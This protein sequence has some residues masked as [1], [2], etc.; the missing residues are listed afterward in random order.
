MAY[1][2]IE[3]EPIKVIRGD[4]FDRTFSISEE[5]RLSEGMTA[6]AQVREIADSELPILSFDS[7]DG[8]IVFGNQDVQL[9]KSASAMNLAAKTYF[10][11]VQFTSASGI[12]TT[13]FGGK[14]IVRE[15]YTR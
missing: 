4:S 2:Y 12:V 11:D 14:F 6:K 13:L 3:I 5:F 15:D 1:E 9:I 10:F 7:D 8:S